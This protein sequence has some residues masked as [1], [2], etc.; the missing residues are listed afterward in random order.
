MPSFFFHKLQLITVLLLTCDSYLSQSKRFVSRK[1]CVGFLNLIPCRFYQ[2]LY[3]CST[4]GMDSL[5]LKRHNSFQDENNRKATH[6]FASR[7]LI[8]KLQ[9]DGLKFNET[10]VSWSSPRLTWRRIF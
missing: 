6:S 3:F 4:K 10:C 8:F 7:P 9:Q 2:S 1:L 5:T